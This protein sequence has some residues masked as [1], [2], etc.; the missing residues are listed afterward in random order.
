[1]KLSLAA[2]AA[3]LYFEWWGGEKYSAAF[4][5]RMK[6]FKMRIL[7]I[8][9]RK[10]NKIRILKEYFLAAPAAKKRAKASYVL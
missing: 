4:D 5:G 3:K 8:L 9:L 10:V 7:F 2:G 1:L 6:F